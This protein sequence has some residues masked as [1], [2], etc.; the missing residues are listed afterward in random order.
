LSANLNNYPISVR[1]EPM[2]QHEQRVL[3]FDI[4]GTLL[5]PNQEGRACFSRALVDVFGISGPIND[6]DM[7]GKTDWQI[8]TEL[9]THAGL[10]PDLVAEKREAVFTAYAHQVEI[11]AP[12]FNMVVLPGVLHLLEVLSKRPEFILGLVTGNVRQA[13]PYKLQAVGIDPGQFTF[14]AF[15]SEHPDRNALP[16]LAISRLEKVLGRSI[17]LE[18]MLVIGDTPRDIACAR[19]AG[20]KVLSVATGH[21]G[22]AV[23]AADHPDYLLDDFTD[24]EAVMEILTSF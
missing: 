22:R 8:V 14:G 19:H 6:F 10:H 11:A 7:A 4:D 20:L 17:D 24:I 2:G 1:I 9:M 18:H 21:F 15:G 5:N 12:T 3:L 23:L 13:V 16:G